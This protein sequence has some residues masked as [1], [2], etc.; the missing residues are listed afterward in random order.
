M[1]E[2][3]LLKM[4]TLAKGNAYLKALTD[5]QGI[6]IGLTKAR[7]DLAEAAVIIQT[8]I[9]LLKDKTTAQE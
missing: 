6:L 7:P 5:V 8:E 4:V 1:P 9:S 2:I 3:D